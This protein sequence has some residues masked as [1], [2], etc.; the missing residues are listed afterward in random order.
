MILNN[1]RIKEWLGNEEFNLESSLKVTAHSKIWKQRL[2]IWQSNHYLITCTPKN[3]YLYERHVF[4]YDIAKLIFRVL[5]NQLFS[6]SSDTVKICVLR[7]PLGPKKVAV[8]DWWSLFR[9][10]L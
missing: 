2:K 5:S 3:L 1:L 4:E 10:H 8:V 6:F 7:P 9:G